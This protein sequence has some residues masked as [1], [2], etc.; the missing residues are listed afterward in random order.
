[1]G[2]HGCG[3]A[4]AAD[5]LRDVDAVVVPGGFGRRGFA[6]KVAAAGAARCAGVPF[7]GSASASAAVVEYARAVLGDA[8]AT[9]EE[10]APATGPAPLYV[11]SMPETDK[12]RLGGTMRLGARATRLREGS[13]AWDLYGRRT[14]VRERH[15][16]R[17]EV[18]PG[19]VAA[20]ERA[21]LRFSGRDETG[22]RMEVL[23]LPADVHPFYMACQYHPEYVSSFD[24]PH[25]LFLGLLRAALKTKITVLCHS[26]NDGHSPRSTPAS[27]PLSAPRGS[28]DGGGG[29]KEDASHRFAFV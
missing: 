9:S 27:R 29:G 19:K 18:D 3:R 4:G 8:G 10:F 20:L 12:T 7:S 22:R 2:R 24:A 17:Y 13:A 21:G 1:M 15:R 5:A 25:P 23:E 11:V 28:H 16:H 26:S 14:S 6:E